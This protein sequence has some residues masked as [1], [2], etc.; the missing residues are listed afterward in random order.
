MGL[1]KRIIIILLLLFF[2]SSLTKTL[3]DY[4]K[5]VAFYEGYRN[6]YEKEKKLN[7]KLKTEILKKS[8]PAEVEKTIRNKLNLLFSDEVAII[9]PYPTPT[10]VTP[11]PTPLPNWQQWWNVFF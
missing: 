2:F 3:F 9:L 6:Q 1:I 11:T 7:T 8:A 5:K 10:I 4:R